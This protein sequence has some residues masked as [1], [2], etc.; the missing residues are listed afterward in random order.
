MRSPSLDLVWPESPIQPSTTAGQPGE[1]SPTSVGFRS[2][3]AANVHASRQLA[4]KQASR[5][6]ADR[7]S[8]LISVA[9]SSMITVD[10]QAKRLAQHCSY[11]LHIYPHTHAHTLFLEFFV[12]DRF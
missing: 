12:S 10:R 6:Y 1:L 5:L 9:E 2:V 4:V 7:S 3:S 11:K 8:R